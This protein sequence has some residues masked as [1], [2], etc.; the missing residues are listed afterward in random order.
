MAVWS[1]GRSVDLRGATITAKGT[2]IPFYVA[3]QQFERDYIVLVPQG[4]LPSAVIGVRLDVTV[5]GQWLT[6]EWSFSTAG[7]VPPPSYHSAWVSESAWPTIAV[8]QTTTLSVTFQ[9]AGTVSWTKGAGT[10][11]NLGVNGDDRTVSQLGMAVGWPVPDRPAVQDAASVPPGATS[12]FTFAIRGVTPG[13]FSIHL[14]PVIDGVTWMEDQGVYMVV[15]V[16]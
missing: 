14:R 8:G 5:A 15:T 1:G 11:A 6:E 16:R 4:P 13:T 7:A 12:S 2:A 9:N 3:P 10:Q